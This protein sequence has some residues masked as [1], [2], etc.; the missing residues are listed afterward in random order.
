M[1][2]YFSKPKLLGEN[3]KVEFDLSSYA[4]TA[5]LQKSTSVD[6]T[7]FAKKSDLASLKSVD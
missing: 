4:R 5:D 2:E 6:F 7:D 3:V 1:S